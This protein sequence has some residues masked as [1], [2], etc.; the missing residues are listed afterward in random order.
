MSSADD[1]VDGLKSEE[2][3][4]KEWADAAQFFV[5]IRRDRKPEEIEPEVEKVAIDLK[6]L[7]KA[8]L[9]YDPTGLAKSMSTKPGLAAG[10]GGAALFGTGMALMS[11]GRKELGGQSQLEHDLGEAKKKR[12][13]SPEPKG[14]MGKLR[15]HAAD[16]NASLASTARKHPIKAG[17]L[18]GFGGAKAGT[19]LLQAFSRKAE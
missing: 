14:M 1:F 17:L 2:D 18:A 8:A 13:T 9:K 5:D 10:L 19:K 15:N 12:D 11:R 3:R 4:A 16:L 7:G 6:H